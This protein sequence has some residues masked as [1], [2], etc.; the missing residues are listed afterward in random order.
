MLAVVGVYAYGV[1][2]LTEFRTAQIRSWAE[3]WLG[4]E[5]RPVLTPHELALSG[6][7]QEPAQ[8]VQ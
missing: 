8:A 5:R 3:H 1:A 7:R 2:W 6:E 4:L